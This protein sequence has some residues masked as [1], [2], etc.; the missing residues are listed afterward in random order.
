MTTAERQSFAAMIDFPP[1]NE[2]LLHDV[3]A[4]QLLRD[5]SRSG[6]PGSQQ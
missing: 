1:T 5:P 3:G 4:F 6:H 2:H